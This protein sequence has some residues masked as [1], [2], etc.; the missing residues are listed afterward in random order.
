MN[1]P[2]LNEN[3][4]D[5]ESLDD[6]LNDL[7]N[8]ALN[9]NNQSTPHVDSELTNMATK[10]TK[11]VPL[12]NAPITPQATPESNSNVDIKFSD[13][14]KTIGTLKPDKQKSPVSMIILFTILIL[15]IAFMPQIITL[16]NTL[17]GTNLNANNGVNT[18]NTSTPTTTTDMNKTETTTDVTNNYYDINDTTT[19]TIDNLK[20]SSMKKNNDNLSFT[21]L[22]TNST[23]YSFTK[24]LFFEF[25]DNNN[26]FISRSILDYSD[27]INSNA[28]INASVYLGNDAYNK[29]TKVELVLRSIDD[30]PSVSLTSDTLV[31]K[32]NT[33][34]IT[35]TFKDSKLNKILDVFTYTKSGDTTEYNN[36]VLTYKSKISKMDA[37]TGVDAVLTEN[38]T[39]FI[40]STSIDYS[41]ASYKDLTTKTN[42]YDSNTQGK[43]VSFE[44]DAKGFTCN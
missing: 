20:I 15:F 11:S 10:E 1:D 33:N 23:N 43:V 35:Y 19:I 25:Y 18:N 13:D 41:S 4:N 38:T 40:T 39:G 34:T 22:N 30:Y 17:L 28:T 29:A 7:P 6:I 16:T 14:N 5:I 21:I 3:K 2:K 36:Q 32:N 8:S 44:M 9:T 24:K 31:C 26:T 37:L 12:N 27:A 42:Y